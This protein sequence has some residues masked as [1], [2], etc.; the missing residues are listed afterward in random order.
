M[1]TNGGGCLVV[2]DESICKA[3]D[4]IKSVHQVNASHTGSVG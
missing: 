3:N 2:N 1:E 4:Y